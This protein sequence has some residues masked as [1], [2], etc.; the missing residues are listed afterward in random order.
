MSYFEIYF[1]G[2][3]WVLG[4]FTLIWLVSVKLK[5]ASIVD[6][7]WGTGFVIVNTFYFLKSGDFTD[8]KILL[9]ALVTIWGLRLS[10]YIFAR[11]KGKAEDFRYQNFRKHY[12]E[13]R[14]WWFSYFQVFLL[15]GFLVWLISAPLLSVHYFSSGTS[16][17]LLDFIALTVWFIGFMFEAGG[18]YQMAKFKSNPK[19][20]E[21]VLQTGFW[22]YTRH[23]NYFGD[24]TVW[25]GFGL[26]S[27]AAGSYIPLLG[28]GFNDLANCKSFGSFHAGK[29]AK[30]IK[31]KI[32]RVH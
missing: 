28:P 17:N 21:K 8:R 16:L 12:G 20:N 26:F 9:F 32:Q 18:D 15:Q 1:Y 6:I 27:V 5:N 25:W 14:Y 23:P 29:N 2:L 3:L 24:A 31:T 11:N 19:N 30:N 22:K 4:F 10:I 7:F 13:H